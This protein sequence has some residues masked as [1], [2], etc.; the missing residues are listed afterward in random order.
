MQIE[1]IEKPLLAI[2][3]YRWGKTKV[4]SIENLWREDKKD[5]VD[6]QRI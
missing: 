4:V 6:I 3:F 5:I 1:N 2:L